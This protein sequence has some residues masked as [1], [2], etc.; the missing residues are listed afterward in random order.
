M[1]DVLEFPA[2]KEALGK[3]DAKNKALHDIFAEAGPEMDM[4]K[5]KSLSGDSTAKVE[6]IRALNAEIDEAAAEVEKNKGIAAAAQRA[7]TWGEGRENGAE[8][9]DRKAGRERGDDGSRKSVGEMFVESQ[10]FK[11]LQGRNGPVAHL[12]MDLKALFDTISAGTPETTRGPRIVDFVTRPIQMIDIIPQTTTSQTAVTYMEETTYVNNAAEIPEGG[13]YPESALGLEEKSSPVRKVGTWIPATDETFEDEPRARTY[14]NNRLPFMVR[15]RLDSQLIVGSGTGTN[16]RGILNTANIQTQAK[17]GDP[18]PDAVYKAM[19]KVRVNGLAIPGATL[20]HPNDWQEVRLLRTTD[21]IY[22][23]GNPSE[24]GPERIWGLPVVQ[25]FGM[26]EGTAVVGDFQNFSELAV[27]RGIDVQISNSHEDF[28]TNGKLAIRA[29]IRAAF[30][31]YRPAAFATV[32][33]V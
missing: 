6:A 21:G 1:T 32:T 4:A 33:G 29:D 3:L 30:I 12:K 31:I 23:W 15:Q 18:T 11:G 10:A 25:V 14:V 7:R 13:P 26:T 24:A 16:L 2:L 17:G 5:V 22:I 8:S 27:K 20:W 19:T 9:G 28:F